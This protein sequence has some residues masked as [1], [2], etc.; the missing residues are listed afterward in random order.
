[1]RLVTLAS[2]AT[3]VG[4]PLLLHAQEIMPAP[5]PTVTPTPF[6]TPTPTP[7]PPVASKVPVPGSAV[8]AST[9]DVNLPANSVDGSLATRWSGFGSG[10]WLQL[11]LGGNH[12]VAYVKVAA[13]LGNQRANFFDLQT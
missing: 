13:Y 4:V 10:A 5:T 1:M 6:V 7:I 9:S 2:I 3:F 8:T 12:K 11:D